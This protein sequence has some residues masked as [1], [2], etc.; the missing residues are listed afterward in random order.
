M[1]E[2]SLRCLEMERWMRR[3][4]IEYCFLFFVTSVS[5]SQLVK[6]EY[7]S[8]LP[9]EGTPLPPEVPPTTVQHPPQ[10]RFR[11][12]PGLNDSNVAYVADTTCGSF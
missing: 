6:D 10:E 11:M 3:P 4:R 2:L 5:P 8:P 9:L 12:I 7:G 1:V